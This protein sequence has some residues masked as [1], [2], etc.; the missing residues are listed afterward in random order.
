MNYLSII[1]P[2]YKAEEII[3]ELVKRIHQEVS[4]IT[5]DYEVILVDDGSP[6]RSWSN[7]EVNCQKDARVKGIRLS[8]NFGQHYAVTA[9][10]SAAN[11]KLIVIMDCDLQDDPSHIASLIDAHHKGNE[12]V[13]TRRIERK[14]SLQKR[15]SAWIYN[16]LFHFF[17][18]SQYDVDVGSLVLFTAKVK[19]TVLKLEDRDRLYV[20]MLKWVGYKSTYVT[21]EH[22]KRFSG[23]S[24]YTIMK[25]LKLAMQGW[26]SHSDKLLRL[27]IYGGFML[28]LTTF[29]ISLVIIIRYFTEGFQP[30]WP[31]LFIA[32][33]FS[34]GLILISIGI[35][36]IYIGKTF[37]QSKRR[38]LFIVDKKINL[39]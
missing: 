35:A 18:E 36:G 6:D 27:S 19:D 24:S 17:S 13:F 23:E 28:S 7:I 31:S 14:H 30:G 9:G 25:L 11:G 32:I 26:T 5:S 38:P 2:V 8:R 39:D 29:L 22:K 3:D 20:Q 33:M 4:K 21:V 16:L 12:I 1:S 37:E 10:M 15:I 34:T